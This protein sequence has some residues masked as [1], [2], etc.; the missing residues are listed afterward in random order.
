M[1]LRGEITFSVFV[2]VWFQSSRKFRAKH[3]VECYYIWWIQTMGSLTFSKAIRNV[4]IHTS[5]SCFCVI[6]ILLIFLSSSF[7][8]PELINP[9]NVCTFPFSR[10]SR[11]GPAGY[12]W[13]ERLQGLGITKL[14]VC[15][16]R[17]S[18]WIFIS[19]ILYSTNITKWQEG[20]KKKVMQQDDRKTQPKQI[21]QQ[22]QWLPREARRLFCQQAKNPCRR[23]SWSS[24]LEMSWAP[25]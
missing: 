14:Y 23:S 25:C 18:F 19:T 11:W 13:D 15:Q 21:C 7:C 16:S 6:E 24:W 22:D 10:F 1:S 12:V 17:I 9:P 8:F 4:I 20:K 3:M 5:S 2:H